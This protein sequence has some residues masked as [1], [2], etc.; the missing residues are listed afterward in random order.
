MMDQQQAF[1]TREQVQA[2]FHSFPKNDPNL[3]WAS[4]GGSQSHLRGIAR[5]SGLS[6]NDSQGLISARRVVV[7]AF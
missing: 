6:G 1:L 2:L 3:R 5:A 7:R 4:R